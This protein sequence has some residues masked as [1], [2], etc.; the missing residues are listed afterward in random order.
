MADRMPDYDVE[1]L[2]LE[3]A[4]NEHEDTIAK[5]KERIAEIERSKQRNL[6]R[7]AI[8][9]LDL[10]TEAKRLLDNE[11]ALLKAIDEKKAN[12]AAMARPTSG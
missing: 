7:V 3:L 8:A 5:G 1:R 4:I 11:S 2:R 12:L 10:D 6:Q 9:N